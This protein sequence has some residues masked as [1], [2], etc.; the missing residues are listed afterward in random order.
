MKIYNSKQVVIPTSQFSNKEI[1]RGV[2]DRVG[3]YSR[4][5]QPFTGEI[6]QWSCTK[7]H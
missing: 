2:K 5:Q 4:Q 3:I 7:L 1:R 6:F